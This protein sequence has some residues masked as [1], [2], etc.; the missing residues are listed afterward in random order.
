METL[1]SEARWL[2][3]MDEGRCVEKQVLANE[4]KKK[5]SVHF[6]ENER[7]A[8]KIFTCGLPF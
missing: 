7:S 2:T 5:E 4:A 3:W 1:A 6:D 8:K